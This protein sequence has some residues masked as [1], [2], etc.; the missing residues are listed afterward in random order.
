MHSRF[1]AAGFHNVSSIR[2]DSEIWLVF[3]CFSDPE[4]LEIWALYNSQ[5]LASICKPSMRAACCTGLSSSNFTL[6]CHSMVSYAVSSID[7]FLVVHGGSWWFGAILRPQALH[8]EPHWRTDL[9]LSWPIQS[10][11]VTRLLGWRPRWEGQDPKEWRQHQVLYTSLHCI[12]IIYICN[13]VYIY[14]IDT[15]I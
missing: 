4:T 9:G 14:I 7:G 2:L 12:S 15:C 3:R 10:K 11:G 6:G 1:S 8:G 13:T 5:K